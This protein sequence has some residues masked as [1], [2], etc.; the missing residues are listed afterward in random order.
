MKE[1]RVIFVF[2][3]LGVELPPTLMEADLWI[4]IIKKN[5]LVRFFV[6]LFSFLIIS[7][8]QMNLNIIKKSNK[9]NILKITR[10][11]VNKYIKSKIEESDA[12]VNCHILSF[13]RFKGLRYFQNQWHCYYS[14]YKCLYQYYIISTQRSILFFDHFS[15]NARQ[16]QS[17]R[18]VL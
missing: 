18:G 14:K 10:V 5:M 17:P 13:Q 7:Q 3:R 2:R 4:I 11:E 15:E 8:K 16:K 12:D 6:K 1:L 9:K